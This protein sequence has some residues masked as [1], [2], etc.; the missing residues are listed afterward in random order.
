MCIMA[1]KKRKINKHY[2]IT[3]TSDYSAGKSKVYRC[4]FNFIRV[5]IICFTIILLLVLWHTYFWYS[6]LK[7]MEAKVSTFKTAISEQEQTIIR[8]GNELEDS[9]SEN[10]ILT[11]LLSKA[12]I[13]ILN[14]EEADAQKHMPV[15]F[16]VKGSVLV[17]DLEDVS[18]PYMA[19]LGEI[20]E[21]KRQQTEKDIAEEYN[22]VFVLKANQTSDMI[23]SGAGTVTRV[24]EDDLFGAFVVVDHGNGYETVYRNN[25]DM[26]V[27]VGD[28][29]VRGQL[30]FVNTEDDNFFGFQVVHNGNY[31]DPLTVI[32]IN[33]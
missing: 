21:D 14:R 32:S 23:A 13:D 33:G 12:E 16:P 6:N 7:G 15:L 11:D 26:K 10:E 18:V 25:G 4:R 19:G 5:G 31:V 2:T 17:S 3:V 30:I 24:G 27:D 20:T 9:E 28:E 29:L 8:L 1:R 22:N